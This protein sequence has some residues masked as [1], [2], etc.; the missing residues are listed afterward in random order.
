MVSEVELIT[1][2]EIWSDPGEL[3]LNILLLD[4]RQGIKSWELLDRK[5]EKTLLYL[6]VHGTFPRQDELSIMCLSK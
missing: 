4:L 2:N 5:S 6:T 3:L 1:N